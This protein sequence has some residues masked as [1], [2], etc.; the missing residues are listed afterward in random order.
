M[1][2]PTRSNDV[3]DPRRNPGNLFLWRSLSQEVNDC[4]KRKI[5]E[6]VVTG[7]ARLL[8]WLVVL[9]QRPSERRLGRALEREPQH[10]R[11][12]VHAWFFLFVL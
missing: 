6:S 1:S 12:Q 7:V 3:S 9:R 5:Q 2:P 8:A 4:L 10:E 11:E